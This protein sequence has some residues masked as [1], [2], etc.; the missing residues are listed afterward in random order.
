MI[1]IPATL[2]NLERIFSISHEI[3]VN[4]SLD[5]ILRSI[6]QVSTE[7]VACEAASIFMLDAST[8]MLNFVTATGYQDRLFNIPVPIDQSIAG[9]AFTSN[10]P[11]IVPDVSNDA[12]YYP[13]VDQQTKFITHSIL[14]VPLTFRER[15]IGVLEVV[16]KKQGR[17]DQA[18]VEVMVVLAAQATIAIEIVRLYRQA[19]DEIAGRIKVE[20]ELRRH[21]DHLEELVKERS[22]EVHRLAIT[23]PL[24]GLSNRHQLMTLGNQ[25]LQRAQRYH[26]P[27]SALMVECDDFKK[28]NDTYG[29]LMGDAA[30]RELAGILR[31]N[32]RATDVIGRFGGDEFVVLM[33]HTDLQ[34]ARKLAVRLLKRIRLARIDTPQGPFGMTVSIGLVEMD[35]TGQQ[36][37]DSLIGKADQAMYAAK[38]AGRDRI[39][40]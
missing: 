3:V 23:D 30:L 20:E 28:I 29:H 7:L 6:I 21:Q 2:P 8:N 33:P 40:V 18:D 5:D 32:L 36:S 37:L 27:F 10:S 4:P 25:L 15:K 39:A 35:Q 16:N 34:A 13:K 14:A 26:T 38:Q 22:A 9:A 11:V 17:F 19:Q 12:R 1:A 31:Q 24:T